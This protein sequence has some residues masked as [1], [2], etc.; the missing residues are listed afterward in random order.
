MA[1]FEHQRVCIKFCVKNGFNGPQT[2][3][4]LEKCF[5]ND[6]LSRSNVFRWHERFR[7][8]RESVED[9]KRSGRPSTSKTDENIAKIEEMLSENRKLTIRELAEDLNIA[10]GSVQDVL[11]SD[12]GLRRPDLWANNSWILHHDNAPAHNAILI[13]EF[14]TK[15]NTNTIQQ[16]SNSPDLAPRDFFLFNRLK[17]PLRGTRYS[18]REEVMTKSKTALMDIP[19]IEY[20]RCFEDWI[21]RW[22]KCIAVDG[23]YFE[24]DHIDLDE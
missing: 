7:S 8:G 17:K 3:D 22:R 23:E 20:Q 15:N 24:G 12:L 16:P 21:K 18:T 13:R 1:S 19:K 5:G 4:M 9:D 10:Y 6:T 2:L 14:L 11:V